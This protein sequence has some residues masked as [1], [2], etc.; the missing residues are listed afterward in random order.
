MR[1]GR[2]LALAGASV[3]VAL[4]AVAGASAASDDSDSRQDAVAD[5]G[6]QVMGFDLDTTVHRFTPTD[7][8]GVQEVV[9]RDPGDD[10]EVR[11]VQAHLREEADRWKQGDFSAPAA[12]HGSDMPG[13]QELG[14]AGQALQVRY[15]ALPDGGRVIFTS[16]EAETVAAL[17]DWFDA[18]VGDHGEHAEHG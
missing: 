1:R 2:A 14:A 18:Q 4:A 8:G 11:D 17:H 12:I 15:E 3:L 10:R 7:S 16:Q 5:R 13:L 9:A 6:E